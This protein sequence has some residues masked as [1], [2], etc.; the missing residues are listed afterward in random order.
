MKCDLFKLVNF[1]YSILKKITL[2]NL[3]NLGHDGGSTYIVVRL[4]YVVVWQF[5]DLGVTRN[6]I[7]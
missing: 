5:G 1:W 6:A 3:V 4:S 7:Q 2:I